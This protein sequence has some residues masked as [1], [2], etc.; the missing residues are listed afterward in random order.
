MFPDKDIYYFPVDSS[1]TKFVQLRKVSG[2][3]IGAEYEMTQIVDIGSTSIPNK[4]KKD[5]FDYLRVK[6]GFAENSHKIIVFIRDNPYL[7]NEDKLKVL[8]VF[9]DE[10]MENMIYVVDR[11]HEH[12]TKFNNPEFFESF[13]IALSSFDGK[14][15][16]TFK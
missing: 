10:K 13:V 16:K 11:F 6:R 3:D 5:I 14:L 9:K 7:S 1:F 15:G 2:G 12:M 8:S 4:V